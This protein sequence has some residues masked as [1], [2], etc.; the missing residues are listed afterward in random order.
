MFLE[1]KKYIF[2][3]R[4]S[5]NAF[6]FSCR[7]FKVPNCSRISARLSDGRL[8][9]SLDGDRRARSYVFFQNKENTKKQNN[10]Q[11]QQYN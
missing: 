6:N 4:A 5:T 1:K 9:L 11:C 2:T 8:R 10:N 7:S 3:S